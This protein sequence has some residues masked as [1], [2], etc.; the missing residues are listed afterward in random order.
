MQGLQV[1]SVGSSNQ[2]FGH[3]EFRTTGLLIRPLPEPCPA[4]LRN[5]HDE[6][7]ARA[8]SAYHRKTLLMSSPTLVNSSYLHDLE[9]GGFMQLFSRNK[10]IVA[11]ALS[12]LALGA[13]GDDEDIGV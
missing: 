13:C 10:A 6:A 7:P 12:A 5:A 2:F 11:L 4:P 3:H 9:R 8:A 1:Q